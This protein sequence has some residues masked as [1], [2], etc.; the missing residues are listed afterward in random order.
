MRVAVT[1]STGFIGRALV[2]A[3]EAAG[4]EV[5]RLVRPAS[6]AEGVAWDPEAGTVD[7]D[8]LA[9][10]VGDD[11]AVVHLAGENLGARRWTRRHKERVWVSRERG[12]RTLA[13][14]LARM[15]APP[16]AMLSASAIGY[17]GDRG[18]EELV[19]S[20]G[21]GEGFVAEVCRAWE[22]AT[23]PAEE[24][25]IRV[26]H[27]RSGLV[28][29]P[30]GGI[31]PRFLTP[32][33]LG[34]GGALG[35]GTQWMS[36]IALDDEVGAIL[37]LLEGCDV[38]GPVNLTA[39]FPVTNR[40]FVRTLGRQ[41]RRP[42]VLRVPSFALKLALGPEMAAETVLIS[43]RVLPAVLQMQGFPF[44]HPELEPALRALLAPA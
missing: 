44:R 7:T 3:L 41:L 12:T 6:R 23:A 24:A 33:R 25:G 42:T 14:A 11:W 39:P 20:S 1:G 27:L 40:E 19:E 32:V 18:D 22:A 26:V 37:H 16:R 43:Q 13:E 9:A 2:P 28:L 21:P 8:G 34:I 30:A 29:S 38:R 36:W 35:P 31:L 15:P 10:A 5:V 17:Y 4:H